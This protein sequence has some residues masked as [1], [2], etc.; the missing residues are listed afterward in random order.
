MIAP[1]KRMKT[2]HKKEKRRREELFPQEM[3][4]GTRATTHEEKKR[5][6]PIRDDKWAKNNDKKKAAA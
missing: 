5:T 1:N 4:F 6:F 3:R 2:L